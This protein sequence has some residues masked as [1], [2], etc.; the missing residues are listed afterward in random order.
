MKSAW[1]NIVFIFSFDPVISQILP[2]S[3]VLP[4]SPLLPD[5]RFSHLTDKDGL[6]SNEVKSLTQDDDG[7]IWIGT[8]NGLNRFDGYGFKSFYANPDDP[9]SIQNNRIQQLTAG[10]KGRFWG[11][12]ADGIFCFNTRTQ[13]VRVFKSNPQDTN[14]FA[15]LFHSPSIYLDS[16]QLPW[17]TTDD[18]LYHFYDSLHY[19][20]IATDIRSQ[21]PPGPRRALVF[22]A[23]VRD[24]DD[25]LWSCWGNTIFSL[26]SRTKKV[27]HRYPG[28]AGL[29]IRDICFDS[30]NR[31]WVSSWG[32]GLFLFDPGANSWQSFFPSDKRS[33]VYGG[34]EWKIEGRPYMV[35]TCSSPALVLVN[36][37]DL[38]ASPFPFDS[39]QVAFNA[40]PF[41][42]R[43]NILW[44]CTNDGVYYST[45]SNNLFHVI[46]VPSPKSDLGKP[47]FSYVYN[48]KEDSSGYWL[49]KRY[50]GGIFWYDK[51]WRLIRSWD[52]APVPPAGR[53]IAPGSTAGEAFDFQRLGNEMF[54]STESGLSILD[55]VTLQWTTITPEVN[56]GVA[57]LRTIIVKDPQT[58]WIRSFGQ[59]VFVFNPVSKKF[60][61]HYDNADTAA[62]GLPSVMPFL[63]QD[64]QRR[65]FA[66][67]SAGL[68]EYDPTVDRFKK[69]L[70][71]GRYTPSRTLFSLACDKNGLLWIGAE[72]GL[73][74]YNPVTQAIEKTF[75]EDNKIGLVS[76][77]CTD[78]AQ[79]VWFTSNSGYWCWLR[80]PDKVVHFEYSLG[81]PKTDGGTVY[82]TGDGSVYAGGKDAIIRFY[83]RRLIDYHSTARTMILDAVVNDT[84]AAFGTN[85]DGHRQLTLT[86]DRSSFSVDF[87]VIN[88][89]LTGTNQYFYKLTPGDKDWRKSEGGH[90]S[91]YNLQPGSY[92]LEVKGAS[93]L[94]G[95]FTNTDT[96]D[97][98]VN[99]SW[100][101]STWF[102]ISSLLFLC[103]LASWLVRYRIRSVRKEGSFKQKMTEMEMTALRAQM[104]PHF[105]FNSLNS[106]ENF[107]MQNEKRLAS[108]YLNKFASL[109]RMILENSR[110]QAVP[111]VQDME[112]MQLYVDLEKLRFEDKFCYV[113]E[114]D[115][116]LLKG[117]YKVAPLL[118]QPFVENA[119]IHGLAPSDK[120]GLCLKISVR[121]HED[122]I[123]YTIE[124]NGIGRTESMA[125]ARKYRPG[126]KSLG[127]A[128]SRERMD[129]IARQNGTV[130]TL[131]IIDLYEGRKP[132]GTRVV[133]TINIC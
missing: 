83:P 51:G 102:K 122:I 47:A 57:Q 84:L 11:S 95:N 39:T 111:L 28:P 61:R 91:F 67:T 4:G 42:D 101:Q 3:P 62:S 64:S 31:C 25:Q 105:I 117:D 5:L 89:D 19:K 113:T 86:P 124:D 107:I 87:D 98:V 81:L 109:V 44:L 96:L 29:L 106:I 59:G 65:I 38:S 75:K 132:A 90:L 30:Y 69:I 16:T 126:H 14:S 27:T 104:N 21:A 99:P 32:K 76:R 92:S 40:P 26:D 17:V 125:Y 128:I 66:A 1:L 55:L 2:G 45:P 72:N 56:R 7:L 10:T 123:H 41:V 70:F 6:S 37:R 46:S 127:L 63:I 9:Q 52:G 60:I 23:L 12:T 36:E 118:I 112:A 79:N 73:F 121:L 35:F 108:D 53:F 119:I 54:M 13:R 110:T 22:G 24:R 50:Y 78:D 58:W 49:S 18:G 82:K 133:L 43:Q 116:I 130:G 48:M 20:K 77:I 115:E 85:T 34:A 15:N 120:Q 131:D 71:K 80:K 114:I 8:E 68:Y 103:L 129:L 74:A 93:K 97:I 33:V 94:T 100:Y 88:Y